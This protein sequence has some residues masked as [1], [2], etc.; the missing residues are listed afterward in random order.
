[1]NMIDWLLASELF[2]AFELP[3]QQSTTFCRNGKGCRTGIA[4]ARR[5]ARKLRNRKQRGQ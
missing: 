2:S 1:M 4:S 5:Q 3:A